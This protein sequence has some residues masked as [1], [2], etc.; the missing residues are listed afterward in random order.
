MVVSLLFVINVCLAL[1]AKSGRHG[2]TTRE[3]KRGVTAKDERNAAE[4]AAV[5]YNCSKMM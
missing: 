3:A 2:G 1:I 4:V 5:E